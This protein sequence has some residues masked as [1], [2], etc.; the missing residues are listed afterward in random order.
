M[1]RVIRLGQVLDVQLG[2]DLRGADAGVASSSCTARK[3]LLD[4]SRWLA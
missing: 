2:V 3:S 4:C 1:R